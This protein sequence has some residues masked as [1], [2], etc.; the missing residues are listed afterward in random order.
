VFFLW[1]GNT[2]TPVTFFTG[3]N[4]VPRSIKKWIPYTE[5]FSVLNTVRWAGKIKVVAD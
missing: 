1:V 5:V 2:R 4:E 3:G